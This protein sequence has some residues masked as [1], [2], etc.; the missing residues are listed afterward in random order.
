MEEVEEEDFSLPVTSQL[1][2]LDLEERLKDQG[3]STDVLEALLLRGQIQQLPYKQKTM[4]LCD[5]KG[6]VLMN[7]S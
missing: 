7:S 3:Q 1:E 4:L 5:F 2:L 6:Q